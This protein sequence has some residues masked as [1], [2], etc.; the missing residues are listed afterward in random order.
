M[1]P[2]EYGGYS[3]AIDFTDYKV[4]ES[5]EKEL[6]EFNRAVNSIKDKENSAKQMKAM[7]LAI[8]RMIEAAAGKGSSND[9]LGDSSSLNE[10]LL[11]MRALLDYKNKQTKESVDTWQQMIG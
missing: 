11:A 1:T 4:A 7:F 8:V 6:V 5:L 2:F 3:K 10:A 9:I